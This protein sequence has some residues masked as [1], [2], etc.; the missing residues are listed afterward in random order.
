MGINCI[1]P[2]PLLEEFVEE[3]R[4]TEILTVEHYLASRNLGYLVLKEIVRGIFSTKTG[5]SRCEIVFVKLRSGKMYPQ[6][7]GAVYGL[8]KTP[9]DNSVV[10]SLH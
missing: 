10:Q 8:A 3:Y 4:L 2:D 6:W 5:L 1:N 9:N 7:R